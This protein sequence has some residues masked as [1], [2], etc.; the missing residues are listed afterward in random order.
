MHVLKE[1]S[2]FRRYLYITVGIIF[3]VAGFYYF[4]MP[5]SMVIGGVSGVGVLFSELFDIKVSYVV[6]ILNVLLLGLGWLMLGR[7]SFIRSIYG[8][9]L[10]PA[11][12]FIFESFSPPLDM[13]DDFLLYVTFGGFFLGLG[14]GIVIR[15]GGT[16]GGTDIPIKILHRF[17]DLPLSLSIYVVD[18]LI[19]LTGIIVFYSDR[20]IAL[21]L[22]AI[23]TTIVAGKVSDFMVAGSNTLKAVHI[24]TDHPERIKQLVYETIERGLSLVPVEGGYSEKKKH[25]LVSVITRDEYYTIRTI[26]A[27]A[28]PRA[29]VFASPATE[30]QG[31]FT[32]HWED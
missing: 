26:I 13:P 29:F 20:G 32:K 5:A 8:S 3:M 7:K 12:L 1:L 23:L 31:D 14:F 17:L 21:G 27:K 25:M 24:I 15:F 16:S 11:V 4:I 30:I 6:F 9:L 22:Y 19:I 10:F 18:G 2:L 28:D